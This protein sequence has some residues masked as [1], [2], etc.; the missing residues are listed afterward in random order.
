MAINKVVYGSTTLIDLTDSTLSDPSDL[1]SGVT[2]YDRSGVLLTGTGSGGGGDYILTYDPDCSVGSAEVGTAVTH[3]PNYTPSG[4]IH[5]TM[6]EV[7]FLTD[8]SLSGELSA[9]FSNGTLTLSLSGLSITP[10]TATKNV[11][12]SAPVFVGNGVHFNIVG[13]SPSSPIV[14]IGQADYMQI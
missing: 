10:S 13:G 7:T 4:D 3:E 14:D 9:S 6:E 1:K 8:A 12:T 5:Q 11:A 2:A